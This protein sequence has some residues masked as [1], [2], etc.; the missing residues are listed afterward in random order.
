[1]RTVQSSLLAMQA[2]GPV[3]GFWLAAKRW[4]WLILREPDLGHNK[5]VLV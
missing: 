2:I 5:L 4:L 1:M 3:Q